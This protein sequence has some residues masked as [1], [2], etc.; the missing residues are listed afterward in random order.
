MNAKSK[1]PPGVKMKGDTTGGKPGDSGQPN[2][3]A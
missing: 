2:R 3:D 1:S